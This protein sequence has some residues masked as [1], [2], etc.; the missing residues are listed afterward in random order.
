MKQNVIH[1]AA[2][3]VHQAALSVNTTPRA[4]AGTWLEYL[5]S[6]SPPPASY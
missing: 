1:V 3:A 5:S 2:T 4:P 6:P